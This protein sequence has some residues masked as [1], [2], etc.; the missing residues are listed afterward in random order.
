LGLEKFQEAQR[1]IYSADPLRWDGRWR[2]IQILPGM[3]QSERTV[4]RR[5]LKW[6]G[7]GQ[8]S[9]ALLAHPS[10]SAE[11]VR[12]TLEATGLASKIFAFNA[13]T[14]DF[15]TMET[16]RSVVRSA[17]ALEKINA[18]YAGFIKRFEGIDQRLPTWNNIPEELAFIIRILLIHDYRRLLLR[19][20]QLP[21]ELLPKEWCGGQARAL[22]TK[23]YRALAGPANAYIASRFETDLLTKP[24][25]NSLYQQRFGGLPRM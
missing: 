14:E 23:L 5:E 8:I 10:I 25:L 15:I 4:L 20:P 19:D 6:L 16:V 24:T 7:F 1:R 12:R 11:S 17:W 9:P 2:L 22:T 21:D 3:T 13:S 18:G